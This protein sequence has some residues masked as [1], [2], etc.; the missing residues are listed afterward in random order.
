[1]PRTRQ[2]SRAASRLP[3]AIFRKEFFDLGD[4]AVFSFKNNIVS[5]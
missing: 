1:M 2:S 4:A 5:H 3:D